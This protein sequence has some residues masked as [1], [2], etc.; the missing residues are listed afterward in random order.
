MTPL[1]SFS[2]I[3]AI[4]VAMGTLLTM[5][6]GGVRWLVKHYLEEIKHEL[7]PNGGGSIKDQVNELTNRQ[8]REE[9]LGKETYLKVEK[10][11][12]KLDD[13]YDKFIEFLTKEK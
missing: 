1:E 5:T 6:V 10:L 3:A 2:L 11:D 7:K 9:A 13:L 8:T 12:K 4:T